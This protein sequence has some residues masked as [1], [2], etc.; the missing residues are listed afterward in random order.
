METKKIKWNLR[1]DVF[2]RKPEKIKY[3]KIDGSPC[4]SFWRIQI[5]LI[6]DKII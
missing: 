4:F 1:I 6:Y 2:H 5:C 3:K